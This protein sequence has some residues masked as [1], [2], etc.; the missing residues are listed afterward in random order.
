[1]SDNRYYVKSADRGIIPHSSEV[2]AT[3]FLA[4]GSPS[5]ASGFMPYCRAFSCPSHVA[6]GRAGGRRA[7]AGHGGR[8]MRGFPKIE[9]PD[10]QTVFPLQVDV[11]LFV[12]QV[13]FTVACAAEVS[14]LIHAQNEDGR[15][16]PSFCDRFFQ[17]LFLLRAIV[18]ENGILKQSL[19]REDY[20]ARAA[21]SL[22]ELH[23]RAFYAAAFSFG[24]GL[25]GE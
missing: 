22:Y 15:G 13:G 9:A 20:I 14:R 1:M 3:I 5:G 18:G 16:C 23:A 11:S 10:F 7:R 21:L 6:P 25:A 4:L 24:F 12:T 19:F 8:T 17:S 2:R